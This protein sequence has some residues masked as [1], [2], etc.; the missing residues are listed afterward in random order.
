MTLN[1]S[2]WTNNE[3]KIHVLFV[4]I[5]AAFKELV[6]SALAEGSL[7]LPVNSEIDGLLASKVPELSLATLATADLGEA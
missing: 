2:Q 7:D 3:L 4:Q 5:V 6:V 1:E